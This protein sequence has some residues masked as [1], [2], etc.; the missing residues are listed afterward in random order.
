MRHTLRSL[1]QVAEM[2]AVVATIV[3]V[4]LCLLLALVLVL[5]DVS[6]EAVASFGGSLNLFAGLLGW[7]LIALALACVYVLWIFPEKH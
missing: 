1:L 7:W 6:P 2:G 3:Y 4:P 5:F